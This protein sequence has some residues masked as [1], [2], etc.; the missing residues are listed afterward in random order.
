MITL[1]KN[2]LQSFQY[3]AVWFLFLNILKLIVI[4]CKI[5][6]NLLQNKGDWGKF[7]K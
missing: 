4:L 1:T 3:I 5:I 7:I 2:T 6:N